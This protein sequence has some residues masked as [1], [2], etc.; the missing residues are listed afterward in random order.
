MKITKFLLPALMVAGFSPAVMA[1]EALEPVTITVNTDNGTLS[2]S[3]NFRST[4]TSTLVDGVQ[5]VSNRPNGGAAAN[6]FK[7]ATGWLQLFTGNV[8]NPYQTDVVISPRTEGKWYVSA[9]SFDV[10]HANENAEESM[11][12]SVQ[13]KEGQKVSTTAIAVSETLEEGTTAT[14]SLT[15]NNKEAAVLENF[16]VTL[17][18]NPDY[19]EPEEVCPVIATEIVQGQFSEWATWYNLQITTSAYSLYDNGE[20]QI[21]LTFDHVSDQ[22]AE[23]HQWCFVEQEDGT[24]KIYNR[25]A[26]LSKVLAAPKGGTD[27]PRMMAEGNDAYC[28]T[29]NVKAAAAKADGAALNGYYTGKNPVYISLSDNPAAILN[30]LSGKGKLTFWTGGYDDGSVVVPLVIE[31]RV[32]I[33]LTTGYLTRTEGGQP[34]INH[35]NRWQSLWNYSAP[36]AVTFGTSANNLTNTTGDVVTGDLQMASGGTSCSYAVNLPM[37]YYLTD[38]SAKVA[39]ATDGASATFAI[40]GGQTMNLT[41]TAKQDVNLSN[42]SPGDPCSMTV[43]GTNNLAN[44]VV[45]SDFVV[46]IKRHVRTYEPGYSVFPRAGASHQRRIPAFTVVGG[47]GLNAGRLIAVYDYRYCNGDLGYGNI[48][49]EIATSDDNGKTWTTPDFARDA[50]GNPVTDYNRK[51]TKADIDWAAACANAK[52]Y[53]DAAWGDAAIC[54]DRETGKVLMVA[55]GGPTGF[56]A[57]RYDSPQ[58]AI[59]WTS[60]DGGATW[61]APE[62]ITYKIYDLFNDEPR[63]GKIDGMF[64]GSG[65]MMQSRYVKVGKYYRVYTVISTQNN[66]GSTRNFVL[67]T[68]DMGETWGVLGGADQCPVASNADEPKAEELPDGSVLLAA[69]GNGGNRNYNIFRYTNATTGEGVWNTFINTDLGYGRINACDGEIYFLPVRNV[70]TKET[71]FMA[72]QSFPYGGSRQMVSIAWKVIDEGA[73]FDTPSCFA[74]W[75]G[76]YQ[77]TSGG[78]ESAYSTMHLQYDH[79]MGFFYE[80]NTGG[81]VYDGVYKNLSLEVIT[82]GKYEYFPDQDNAIAQALTK[83]MVL[84]RME[85]YNGENDE[86]VSNAGAEYL[87]APT[88]ANYIKFNRAYYGATGDADEYDFD[89]STPIWPGVEASVKALTVSPESVQ[90]KVGETV[91]LT[92]APEPALTSDEITWSSSNE[93]VATVDANGIVTAVAVGNATVTAACGALTADCAVTVVDE[94]EDGISEV[95]AADGATT[96]YDLQGRKVSKAATS[97]LYIVNG[98]KAI[99]K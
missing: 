84:Y 88:Y 2:G 73:D 45:I 52:D 4:W 29:W 60:D 97:G 63:N 8:G 64:F 7:N 79:N 44:N 82:D 37:D 46:G 50:E 19:V 14:F 95:T 25:A 62:C 10:K 9:Y 41:G 6:N 81:G 76:R 83:D 39:V 70:E 91:T 58:S 48:S 3:G 16:T 53:W 31:T 59:R 55:V 18:P 27:F 69:R 24:F 17:T 42:L 38:L 22:L 96:I 98:Q 54:S 80:E 74:T 28:Y 89:Y 32:A 26:G 77:V 1:E 57:S 47:K 40:G 56:W 43:G 85:N 13:G 93:T 65:R 34:V 20:N 11:T 66:G 68:D 36:F 5:I 78:H 94:V 61:S 51:H 92:A 49:L 99:V 86:A 30:N 75:N 35:D 21:E 87:D 33:N 15:G 23:D 72:L 90:V 67:Y 12:I 71:A